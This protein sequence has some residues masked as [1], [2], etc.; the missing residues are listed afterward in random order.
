LLPVHATEASDIEPMLAH[1]REKGNKRL[2]QQ[3][4]QQQA[5]QAQSQAMQMPRSSHMPLGP[6]VMELAMQQQHQHSLKQYMIPTIMPLGS[7]HSGEQPIMIVS[8]SVNTMPMFQTDDILQRGNFFHRTYFWMSLS[9][10]NRCCSCSS[11]GPKTTQGFG[12]SASEPTPEPC[13]VASSLEDRR[14]HVCGRNKSSLES[15]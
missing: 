14:R 5:P 9:Q 2:M 10:V 6:P 3:T 12:C 1:I 11:V 7:D 8:N 4:K 15:S 13:R